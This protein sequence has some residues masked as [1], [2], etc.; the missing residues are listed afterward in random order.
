MCEETFHHKSNLKFHYYFNHDLTKEEA[1]K[2]V[3]DVKENLLSNIKVETQEKEDQFSPNA[4]SN[5]IDP[6]LI[7]SH[8]KPEAEEAMDMSESPEETVTAE[9]PEPL[10]DNQDSDI[11]TTSQ[12]NLSDPSNA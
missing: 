4:N 5:N 1:T 12:E 11:L 3:T 2:K 10:K 9:T 6:L 7:N 8:I